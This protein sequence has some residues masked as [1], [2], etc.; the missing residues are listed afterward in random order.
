MARRRDPE[1]E[2]RILEAA[3]K[4]WHKGGEEALNMRAVAKAAGTNTPTV[5]R[6]FRDRDDILRALV[7]SYQMDL[8]RS[9]EPCASLRE[10]GQ[11]YFDFA[12]RRP[13]EYE[14]MMSG[15]LARVRK[16][17]PN[18]D[19][20]LRRCAEW[21]G[22]PPD[23][24]KGLAAALFALAH[25]AVTLILT[26]N[27]LEEENQRVRDVFIRSLE[28]LVANAKALAVNS[29]SPGQRAGQVSPP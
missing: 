22:G 14:L 18:F 13:R 20:L 2:G 9:L 27:L 12:L 23:E 5:Y 21:L 3:R 24:H 11:C 28:V 15:M 16:S 4:L 8:F 25:G 7:E 26:R 1:V 17:R 19:L 6:R 10:L 29:Q